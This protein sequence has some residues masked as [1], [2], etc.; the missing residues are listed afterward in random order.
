MS[1]AAE[2]EPGHPTSGFRWGDVC[3]PAALQVCLY[4]QVLHDSLVTDAQSLET[5]LAEA[6]VAATELAVLLGDEAAVEWATDA[7]AQY[8]SNF[9][10]AREENEAGESIDLT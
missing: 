9:A 8:A 6:R 10:R 1:E 4:S 3:D 5:A 7:V 2:R